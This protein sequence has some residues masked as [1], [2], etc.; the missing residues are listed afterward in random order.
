MLTGE[1]SILKRAVDAK[2]RTGIAEIEERI[3]L[4]YNS[5][6]AEDLTTG[7]GKVQEDTLRR[8]LTSEFPGKE[9]DINTA[10][11]EW[12]ITVDGVSV[13]VPAGKKGEEE[14][15]E[16]IIDLAMTH[17]EQKP[18]IS[19]NVASLTSEN[20]PIP[21]GF[22]VVGGNKDT[23]LII[24]DSPDDA[25][26]GT[27]HE[28]A[29]TLKGNQ[30]VWV[31]VDQ[32]QKLRLEVKGPEEITS[33]KLT[34]P[35][36]TNI[37]LG[38][39]GTIGKKY[40][41]ENIEPTIN[42][43]YK[44]EITTASG[45]T[46]KTLTVRSLYAKDALNDYESSD[47]VFELWKSRASKKDTAEDVYK[48]FGCNTKEEFEAF[49]RRSCYVS[50][51][52]PVIKNG[53]DSENYTDSVEKNGGFYVGRYEAGL[54]SIRT[55]GN[56]KTSVED[57]IKESGR[58]LSIANKDSYTYVT[59]SQA[60]GLAEKMYEGESHLLTGAAWDRTLGWLLEKNNK[61]YGQVYVDSKEWG[62]YSDDTFS[63]TGI[64]K[65]GKY[66][67][68]NAKGIYD[69]AGNVYEWTS[70][71]SGSST[72]CVDRGGHYNNTGS[73]DPASDRYNRNE[74][75]NGPG[76]GFRVALFL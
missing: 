30:F 28:I 72:P 34:D 26:K 59:R 13:N 8:I 12:V 23:G 58:P 14:P 38:I 66:S 67:Q 6:L 40:L 11:E 64:E 2:E 49:A 46:P 7:N 39:T 33:I 16:L 36:G 56:D 24:S 50:A 69:L 54:T 17:K 75:S 55:K 65:T 18:T 37:N 10:G 31:P 63:V 53:L 48:S 62:N 51:Y 32:N 76:V 68:T 41:N 9:I 3:K 57:L 25:N 74:T 42:G 73:N 27:S 47:A 71:N 22:Y 29:Q 21:T 5:A 35:L 19:G 52:D 15:T 43:V 61:T 1:N 4:S 44:A 60:K 20:I 70:E 45:T